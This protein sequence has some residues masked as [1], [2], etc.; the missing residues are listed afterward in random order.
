MVLV[1]S[2]ATSTSLRLGMAKATAPVMVLEITAKTMAPVRARA[3]M[4]KP[5]AKG[6]KGSARPSSSGAGLD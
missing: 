1:A 5:E 3:L 2:L 4:A 6:E